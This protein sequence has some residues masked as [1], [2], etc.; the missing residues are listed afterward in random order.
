MWY[1]THI[2]GGRCPVV[3][4]L[5]LI[6][7]NLRGGDHRRLHPPKDRCE[8]RDSTPR[9][10]ERPELAHGVFLQIPRRECVKRDPRRVSRLPCRRLALLQALLE[11]ALSIGP[12][13][14]SRAF[15]VLAPADGIC[16]EI[17]CPAL[18]NPALSLHP[19]RPPV[20]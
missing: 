1:H 7:A 5:G 11:E 6:A 10:V 18:V 9:R 14:R 12:D 8:I 4:T 2:G 3:P 19:H 13:G 17:G 15:A 20:S 16:N